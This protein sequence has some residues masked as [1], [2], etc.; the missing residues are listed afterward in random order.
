[1]PADLA[2]D[3]RHAFP[4]DG[5]GQDHCR[6]PTG[7]AG[8]VERVENRRH[9]VAVDH[10]RVPAERTPPALELI[11]VVLPHGRA[12]LPEAVDVRNSAEA[13]EAV[14]GADVGGFPDRS[15]GRLAVA[16]QHIGAVVGFDPA[17]VERDADRGA[18][19]LTE[20]SGRDID[21]GQTR[22]RMSF[23]V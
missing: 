22:R 19:A 5:P 13:V 20:R 18:D 15:F 16:D 14:G 2:F 3:K 17:R 1:M 6:L 7:A 23:E 9:I 10:D 11:H 8:L 4:F 21:E 12:A